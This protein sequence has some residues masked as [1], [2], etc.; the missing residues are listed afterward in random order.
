MQNESSFQDGSIV[1]IWDYCSLIDL[2]AKRR[3]HLFL[4]LHTSVPLLTIF[5]FGGNFA[6]Q[7]RSLHSGGGYSQ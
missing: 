4:K 7:L 6:Y 3:K 2:F 5:V 1:G